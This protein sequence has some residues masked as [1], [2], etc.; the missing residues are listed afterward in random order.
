[1]KH[2]QLLALY[3]QIVI[4]YHP[5]FSENPQ[6]EHDNS[7]LVQNCDNPKLFQV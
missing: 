2:Q 6:L 7:F 1:M 5:G 4:E 3:A